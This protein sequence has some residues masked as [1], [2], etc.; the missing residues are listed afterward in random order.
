LQAPAPNG[1]GIEPKSTAVSNLRHL[2]DERR[3]RT[4]SEVIL[5]MS[6]KATNRELTLSWALRLSFVGSMRE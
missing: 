1:E 6:D 2:D 4:S 5:Y 3:N